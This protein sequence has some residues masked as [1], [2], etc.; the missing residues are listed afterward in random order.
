MLA[1]S[2][3]DLPTASILGMLTR[4]RGISLASNVYKDG[5]IEMIPVRRRDDDLVRYQSPSSTRAT[6]PVG[7]ARHK[8]DIHRARDSTIPSPRSSVLIFHNS[9]TDGAEDQFRLGA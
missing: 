8:Q 2:V 7:D 3:L 1:L 6:V 9:D 4:P 5:K